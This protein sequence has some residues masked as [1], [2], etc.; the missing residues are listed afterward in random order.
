MPPVC[1]S[2]T[3][4]FEVKKMN[5]HIAAY[6]LRL[7]YVTDMTCYISSSSRLKQHPAQRHDRDTSP[8]YSLSHI[9]TYY[10]HTPYFNPP[11]LISTQ[12]DN[13][14]ITITMHIT[15]LPPELIHEIISHLALLDHYPVKLAG[16]RYITEVL[17]IRSKQISY[18]QYTNTLEVQYAERHRTL[19]HNPHHHHHPYY[20]IYNNHLGCVFTF[21][22]ITAL[23][24]TMDRKQLSLLLRFFR[25]IREASASTTTSTTTSTSTPST[26]ADNH[27]SNHH[28]QNGMRIST[29]PCIGFTLLEL[30]TTRHRTHITE[31]LLARASAL[32]NSPNPEIRARITNYQNKAL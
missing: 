23:K 22:K 9:P 32:Q 20:P 15:N 18:T 30:A 6:Q 27:G 7:I 2:I 24:I 26:T 10:L 16:S 19:Q 28:T 13:C 3:I 11:Y 14:S 29:I 31:T 1:C 8:T 4:W 21:P 5:R 17:R 25:I 12:L